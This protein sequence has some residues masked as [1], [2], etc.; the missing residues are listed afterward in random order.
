MSM[1]KVECDLLLADSFE[2]AEGFVTGRDK[3]DMDDV[4]VYDLDGVILY[5]FEGKVI[6]WIEGEHRAFAVRS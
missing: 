5:V 4:E 6:G 2:M 3:H 1:K